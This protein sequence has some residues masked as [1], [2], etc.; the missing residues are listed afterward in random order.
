MADHTLN[1]KPLKAN[2]DADKERRRLESDLK[3]ELAGS[4]AH[5]GTGHGL[6][7]FELIKNFKE[8]WKKDLSDYVT[9]LGYESTREM[10]EAYP[11]LVKLAKLPTGQYQVFVVRNEK[12]AHLLDVIDRTPYQYSPNT[13]RPLHEVRGPHRVEQPEHTRFPFDFPLVGNGNFVPHTTPAPRVTNPLSRSANVTRPAGDS[14]YVPFSTRRPPPAR[15]VNTSPPNGNNGFARS[16][17]LP[18]T[19]QTTRM[20]QAGR[21]STSPPRV[22]D[23]AQTTQAGH[24]STSPPRVLD[25]AQT[26]PAGHN[27]PPRVLDQAPLGHWHT[28]PKIR[29]DPKREGLIVAGVNDEEVII[30]IDS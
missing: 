17:Y 24:N 7:L 18:Q 3:A 28:Q 14:N 25:Q 4:L 2:E 8:E 9:K 23:Q 6:P 10:L 26:T 5:Y 15:V 27:S 13:P 1:T 12:L 30:D 16:A 19:A 11:D 20:A 29:Y 21:N 22:L